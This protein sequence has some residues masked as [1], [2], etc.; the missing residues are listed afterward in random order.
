MTALQTKLLQNASKM[1]RQGGKLV[2]S[3]CSWLVEENETIVEHFLNENPNFHLITQNLYGNP[4]VNAD[5]MFS[6]VMQR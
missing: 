4:S 1:V 2:Y 3:T 6:A 5:T